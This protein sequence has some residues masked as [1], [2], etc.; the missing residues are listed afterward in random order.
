MNRW[1]LL[2]LVGWATAGCATRATPIAETPNDVRIEIAF[3]RADGTRVAAPSA[4]CRA[5]QRANAMAVEPYTYVKDYEV[6]V[7]QECFIVDPVIETL[8]EG[9]WFECDVADAPDGRV[10]LAYKVR[11]AALK[12]PIETFTTTLGAFTKPVTIQIPKLVTDEV[13]GTAD[14]AFGVESRVVRVPVGA[15][16]E[17]VV[18]LA[19][20]VPVS[21]GKTPAAE[22]APQ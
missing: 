9:V 11:R 20:V 14:L 2:A 18:V 5:G 17:P 21:P 6:E 10:K 7:G 15:G 3:E 22:S 12:R 19:R 8:D 1:P 16:A 4:T 13:E